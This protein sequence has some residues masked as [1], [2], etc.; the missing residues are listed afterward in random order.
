[1]CACVCSSTSTSI[2]CAAGMQQKGRRP[3]SQLSG[4]PSFSFL[5]ALPPAAKTGLLSSFFF[6]PICF[7][8]NLW[9]GMQHS[10]TICTLSNDEQS[11]GGGGE[12]SK[13][14]PQRTINLIMKFFA[15]LT[16][17]QAWQEE[18]R[19]QEE[20]GPGWRRIPGRSHRFEARLVFSEW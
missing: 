1:M 16:H 12:G 10:D 3:W 6:F 4:V 8:A 14:E 20:P 7:R 15:S 11:G 9:S 17:G 13:N 2:M 18:D 19:G 5:V